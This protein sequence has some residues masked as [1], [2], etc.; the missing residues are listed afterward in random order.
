MINL[1]TNHLPESVK[2]EGLDE[3]VP[4]N[5]DFRVGIQVSLIYEAPLDADQVRAGAF[6]HFFGTSPTD[7]P[8]ECRGHLLAMAEAFA[9]QDELATVT[10]KGKGS[11]A[12]IRTFDWDADQERLVADF[13]REY[14]MDL[15]DPELHIHWWRFLALLGQL[16]DDSATRTAIGYRAMKINAKL[17]AEEKQRLQKL[18]RHYALPLSREDAAR[19][20]RD[21]WGD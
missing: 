9:S 6:A 10:K 4:I 2:V 3:P 21:L 8:D 19:R 14:G 1:I 20:D 17:P 7:W 18:K 11:K 5:T 16:S 13:Q 12:K 15:T